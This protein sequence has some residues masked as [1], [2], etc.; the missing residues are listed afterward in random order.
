MSKSRWQT[1]QIW[2]SNF[3]KESFSQK[4]GFMLGLLKDLDKWLEN[5]LRLD[6]ISKYAK[7]FEKINS[8]SA[9]R[10]V[11]DAFLDFYDD[12]NFEIQKT[13]WIAKL[14]YQEKRKSQWKP[15]LPEWFAKFIDEVYKKL[16][17][18][19]KFKQFLEAFVAYHK[20]F[21]PKS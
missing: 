21:N 3:K 2:R 1:I 17:D 12:E 18:K 16:W 11:Y 9:L 19:T 14:A 10:K 7:E 4:N 5:A 6:N 15:I 8:S 20:Y 13:I